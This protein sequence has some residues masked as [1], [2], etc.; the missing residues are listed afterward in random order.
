M[1]FS[2]V[3]QNA[4]MCQNSRG[5]YTFTVNAEAARN[6]QTETWWTLN[7]QTAV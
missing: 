7:W 4:H 5:I 6:K 1:P 3:V 2:V